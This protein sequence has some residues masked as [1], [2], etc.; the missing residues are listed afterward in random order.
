[1]LGN[2]FSVHKDHESALKFFK[3][4]LQVIIALRTMNVACKH[5]L[6]KMYSE[7]VG[8]ICHVLDTWVDKSKY[9]KHTHTCR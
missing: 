6:M 4:A 3:R 1:M 7:I 8:C 9:H 2:C 5:S